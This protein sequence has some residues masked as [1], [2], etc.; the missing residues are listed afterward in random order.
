MR[1]HAAP[2]PLT[3]AST[4]RRSAAPGRLSREDARNIGDGTLQAGPKSRFVFARED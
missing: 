3:Q 1:D 2:G 4:P